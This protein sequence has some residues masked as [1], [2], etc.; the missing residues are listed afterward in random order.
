MYEGFLC[1][2][3]PEEVGQTLD[4]S[5]HPVYSDTSAGETWLDKIQ[6]NAT[7]TRGSTFGIFAPECPE[8][9]VSGRLTNPVALVGSEVRSLRDEEMKADF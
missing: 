8:N 7:T 4:H 1:P 9:W 6:Q 2:P 3:P 5:K